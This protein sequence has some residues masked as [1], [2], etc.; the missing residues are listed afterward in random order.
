MTSHN[1]FPASSFGNNSLAFN[2]SNN[3][4]ERGN[5]D[6]LLQAARPMN[7]D[8]FDFIA[9]T[10]AEVNSL[11]GIRTVAPAGENIGALANAPCR[12]KH[13]RPNCVSRTLWPA[14]QAKRNPVIVVFHH[15]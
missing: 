5:A 14:D 4:V 1:W 10:Q 6:F 8:F 3:S 12:H 2:D 13:L 9:S 11:V 15:V 7:L